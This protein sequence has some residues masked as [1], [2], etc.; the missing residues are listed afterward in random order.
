MYTVD[1]VQCPS[2]GTEN[3]ARV[4]DNNPFGRQKTVSLY[5]MKSKLVRAARETT[6][7]F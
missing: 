5:S 3:G 7:Y 4:K 2:D 1:Y 6:D